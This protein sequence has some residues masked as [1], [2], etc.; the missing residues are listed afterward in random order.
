[1][2][3]RMRQS[4]IAQSS[5]RKSVDLEKQM[6]DGSTENISRLI[7]MAL[8]PPAVRLHLP[9]RRTERRLGVGGGG[10]KLRNDIWHGYYYYY[11]L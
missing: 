1:M 11:Y 2:Q 7:N 9:Y 4:T 5:G 6:E 8:S 3:T 10:S